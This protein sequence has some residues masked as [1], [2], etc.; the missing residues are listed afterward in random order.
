MRAARVPEK[1]SGAIRGGTIAGGNGAGAKA[2]AARDSAA[3][4]GRRGADSA[5][6]M[7]EAVRTAGFP[8]ARGAG[9][10]PGRAAKAGPV[11]AARV[12][13]G[14]TEP[15]GVRRAKPC[16]GWTSR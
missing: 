9:V 15:N 4:A 10:F 2:A 7:P 6:R 11:L 5:A 8:A 3:P 12:F 1:G 13:P 16:R 14:G